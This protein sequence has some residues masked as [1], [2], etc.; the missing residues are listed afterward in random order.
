M[1]YLYLTLYL[2]MVSWLVALFLYADGTLVH[3]KIE[4]VFAPILGVFTVV[5]A[6]LRWGF[7]QREVGPSPQRGW[8][9]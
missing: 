2:M 6:G 3:S 1:L 4:V 9:P 8:E 5:S 7:R